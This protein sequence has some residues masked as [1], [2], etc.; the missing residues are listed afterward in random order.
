MSFYFICRSLPVEAFEDED[1]DFKGKED[2]DHRTTSEQEKPR[3]IW[4]TERRC[5][6][7]GSSVKRLVKCI[8]NVSMIYSLL[9]EF[10]H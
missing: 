6:M 4:N 2:R 1:G 7:E 9:V 3:V 8:V 5:Y 10:L